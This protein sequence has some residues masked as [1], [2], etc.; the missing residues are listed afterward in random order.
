MSGGVSDAA[1]RAFLVDHFGSDVVDVARIGHGEWSRAYAYRLHGK[2]YVLRISALLEDFAKDRLA[3]AFATPALPIP[4][5]LELGEVFGGYYATA[6]R[7]SGT[8]LDELSEAGLRR[9][10]P[11]LFDA[12]DAARL[13]DLTGTTGYGGWG[14]DGNASGSSW[15][16]ALLTVGNDPPESRTHGWR[17]SLAAS[18]TGLGPFDE[19][20]A[21][22]HALVDVCPEGRCLIHSDL[23]NYNVLVA[24]DRLTAVLD[25]GCA[26]YGDFLYD[27]AWLTFWQPWYPAWRGIDFRAEAARHYAAVGLAVPNFAERLRCY[28]LH[29][30]LGGMAYNAYRGEERLPALA[31]TA[32]RTLALAQDISSS[33]PARTPRGR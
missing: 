27:L 13:A 20:L 15:R 16:A 3:S 7:A 4:R 31:E 14:E 11:A 24:G 28:E 12:L 2:E 10:L 9:A 23:L 25:W 32:Q 19:A 30:G 21:K 6:E 1:A 5:V 26:M 17:A 8:Y 18:P 29:I 22:L 33:A